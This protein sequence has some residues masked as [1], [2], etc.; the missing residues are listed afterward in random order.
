M[1]ERFQLCA[2]ALDT[3]P[4][5][6]GWLRFEACTYGADGVGGIAFRLSFSTS[7]CSSSSSFTVQRS[8][9]F[10]ETENRKT[11]LKPEAAA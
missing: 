8:E 2:R 9:F 5:R 3:A 7:T 11:K 10:S 1:G 4:H 6:Q